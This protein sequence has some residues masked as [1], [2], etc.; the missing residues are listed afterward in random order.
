MK[1]VLIFCLLTGVLVGATGGW[2][3]IDLKTADESE[4][5]GVS[6]AANFAVQT[7]A[8][9]HNGKSLTLARIIAAY[10]QIVAGINYRLI[11]GLNENGH[12]IT[13]TVVVW[14][15]FGDLSLTSDEI[16]AIPPAFKRNSVH[17]FETITPI[18]AEAGQEQLQPKPESVDDPHTLIGGWTTIDLNK[19]NGETIDRVVSVAEFA[20]EQ[21]NARSNSIDKFVFNRVVQ[22]AEQLVAG[23]KYRLVVELKWQNKIVQHTVV[24]WDQFG[25]MKLLSDQPAN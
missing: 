10:S 5:S 16:G 7:L 4:L 23:M 21:I 22:A 1:S 18:H 15:Q 2:H 19:A 3:Q 25:D 14:D 8:L 11:L 13:H 12:A 9:Q 24:V 17:T 20:V 6:N